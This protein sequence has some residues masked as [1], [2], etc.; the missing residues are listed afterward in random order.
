MDPDH[1]SLLNDMARLYRFLVR[2]RRVIDLVIRRLEKRYQI[3]SKD[4]LE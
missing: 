1:H 2:I 4:E 3:K